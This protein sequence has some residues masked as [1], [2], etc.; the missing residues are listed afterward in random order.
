M[1]YFALTPSET[2]LH[3]GGFPDGVKVIRIDGPLAQR[4]AALSLHKA[5]LDFADSCLIAMSDM[6][7]PYGIV[8]EALWRA[9]I[10]HFLKCFG[11]AGAR[12]QLSA[13]KILKS[14]PPEAMMAFMYF[15]GLRNKHLIHDENSYAQSVPGAVLNKGDKGYKIEKIVCFSAI[16]GTMGPENYGNLKLLI[17]TTRSW[18]VSEFD[19]LCDVLTKEL[20][21]ESHES[22][23]AREALSYR[24]P[25]LDD[26]QK[27]RKAP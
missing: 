5:D 26:I 14:E 17:Q 25:T 9:A 2:G 1:E 3:L 4:L 8:H 21:K 6:K 11:D 16:A 27:N 23:L 24:A 7:E 12:F 18:V 15:K 20:E 13:D 10:V 22:L 19:T